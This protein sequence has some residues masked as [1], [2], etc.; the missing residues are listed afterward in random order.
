MTAETPRINDEDSQA[1]GDESRRGPKR[2]KFAR[3]GRTRRVVEPE[4]PL[5]YKN[6]AYLAKFI[7]PTGKIQSRRR[8]NFS[9]QDQRKL[10]RAIKNARLVG[11]LPFVGRG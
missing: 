8:T 5:E 7:G 1:S 2:G 10:A 4:E 6:V 3:F 11:L 9:G